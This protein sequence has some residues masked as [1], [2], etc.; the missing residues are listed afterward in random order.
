MKHRFSIR[1]PHAAVAASLTLLALGLAGCAA[2]TDPQD[3]PASEVTATEGSALHESGSAGPL[4]EGAVMPPGHPP[5]GIPGDGADPGAS[6]PVATVLETMDS[7]GYTYALLALDGDEI[8]SAGPPSQLSAGDQVALS[9]V[10][11][12]ENFSASSLNRTFDRILFV[13]GY[14]PR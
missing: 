7:G 4:P 8:W 1:P 9:G 2:D 5:I 13:S 14:A 3:A 10:M 12:M 6:A 11:G